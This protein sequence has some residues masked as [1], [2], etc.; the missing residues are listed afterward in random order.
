MDNHTSIFTRVHILIHLKTISGIVGGFTE[1]LSTE[2]LTDSGWEATSTV[3]PVW[4]YVTCMV[5]ID[6]DTYFVF[7][8]WQSDTMNSPQTYMFTASTNSWTRGPDLPVGK[9]G[10]GCGRLPSNETSSQMSIAVVA[11]LNG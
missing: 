9:L 1:M 8:G 10:N 5:A 4:M 11:G 2:V 3:L 6:D 7:G